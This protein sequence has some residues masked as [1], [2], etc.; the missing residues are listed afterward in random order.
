MILTENIT[1]KVSNKTKS[2]FEMKGYDI[3]SDSIIVRITDIHKSSRQKVLVKCDVCGEEKKIRYGDYNKITKNN[4]DIYCCY[5]C[6]RIKT[7]KTN[8]EKYGNRCA[9]QNE[10]IKE[11]SKQTMIKKYSNKSY[12]NPIEIK[13]TF[14]L[15]Y[16]VDNVSKL[17]IIK[18][19]KI[20]TSLLHYNVDNPNKCDVVK[21]KIKQTNLERYGVESAMKNE[22]T[23]NKA[24]KTNL[25]KYG[26]ENVFQND[27]IKKRIKSASLNKYGFDNP[28]KNENVKNKMKI[29]RIK[30][31][32]QIPDDLL[33][34]FA[35]YRKIINSM[36]YKHKKELFSNWS[37]YDYYD[38]EYIKENFVLGKE[39]SLYPTIDHKVSVFYGFVNNIDPK[40][41]SNIENLCITKKYINSQKHKNITYER[42]EKD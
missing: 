7:D 10:L 28:M 6:R 26:C 13:K 33:T 41:I 14:L 29:T 32:N 12:R 17:E 9:M 11:K 2:Y 5:K 42:K 31:G 35:K 20:E 4:V 15:K 39:N 40:D 30:N 34:D 23:I 22:N 3:H 36:T 37:G 19:K 24:K 8:L 21:E 25:E 1:I 18:N 27:I 38:D 16:G